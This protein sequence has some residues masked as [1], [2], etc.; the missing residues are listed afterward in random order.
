MAQV[1]VTLF[2][3]EV[4]TDVIVVYVADYKLGVPLLSAVPKH[5]TFSKENLINAIINGVAF[6]A[7]FACISMA[8]N[9][10]I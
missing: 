8:A 1:A 2:A 4:I 6:N 9:A 3:V 10:K 5:S 7:M